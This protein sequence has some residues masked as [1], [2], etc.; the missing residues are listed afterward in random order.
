MKPT[1]VITSELPDIAVQLL[2]QEHEVV[3]HDSGGVPRSEDELSTI[4]AEADGAITLLSDPLTRS[5]LES[6]PNL[7]VVANYAVGFNNVDIEAA[8]E[9]GIT[10]TNTPGVLTEATADMTIALILAATRRLREGEKV[11]RER[12]FRGWHPL[13]LLGHSLQQK[14]LGIVGMGRI[15]QAVAKRAAAFGLTIIY[16]SRTNTVSEGIGRRVELDELLETADVVTLHVPLNDET[17]HLIDA[18]AL[19]RMKPSA[20]LINTSRGPVVDEEALAAALSTGAIAG[21]GL[22]V[23]EEEPDVDSRLLDL[24]NVV[25]LPHLGSATLEA[26]AAMARIVATD[27]ARVLRGEEPLHRVV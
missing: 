15:G 24:D 3:V 9:L 2:S 16:T 13:M 23:Y 22:D 7:H 10:V 8:R 26:R 5:V 27:V 1:V 17:A 6:N 11:V 12:R 21:A 18:E 19:T 14:V 25:L 4:L 20:Y